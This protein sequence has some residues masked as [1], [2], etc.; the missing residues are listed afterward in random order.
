MTEP[1][2]LISYLTG[3]L[4]TSLQEMFMKFFASNEVNIQMDTIIEKLKPLIPLL[5]KMSVS[6]IKSELDPISESTAG[7]LGSPGVF[8]IM[9]LL[10]QNID[11]ALTQCHPERII[12]GCSEYNKFVDYVVGQGLPL[13][14]E[15]D[16]TEAKK[17]LYISSQIIENH[18]FEEHRGAFTWNIKNYMIRM[19]ISNA[20]FYFKHVMSM[21]VPLMKLK[22]LK[23]STDSIIM[24]MDIRKQYIDYLY[25]IVF[26]QLLIVNM[27]FKNNELFLGELQLSDDDAVIVK[28]IIEAYMSGKACK[29]SVENFI[30]RNI[31]AVYSGGA[32]VNVQDVLEAAKK[33]NT[34][35]ATPGNNATPSNN[36]LLKSITSSKAIK[37]PKKPKLNTGAIE[38]L[39]RL[40]FNAWCIVFVWRLVTEAFNLMNKASTSMSTRPTNISFVLNGKHNIDVQENGINVKQT[41]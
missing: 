9:E 25:N 7:M 22:Q 24:L 28:T 31:N 16:Y 19:I 14:N 12:E 21:M 1:F 33:V 10:T 32:D 11:N 8:P 40:D 17:H 23:P 6:E 26:P 34:I 15:T 5:S 30:C 13:I 4:Q 20:T 35:N 41:K 27:E 36:N 38:G 29:E 18:W 2:N 3:S 37:A 39:G